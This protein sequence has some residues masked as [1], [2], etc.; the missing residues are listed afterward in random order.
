MK[1]LQIGQILVVYDP[2]AGAPPKAPAANALLINADHVS[3]TPSA[4][5]SPDM[6][7]PAVSTA[8]Q[9]S[10][11]RGSAPAIRMPLAEVVGMQ[12][13]RAA[14]TTS[15]APRSDTVCETWHAYKTS[16]ARK[17]HTTRSSCEADVYI[18]MHSAYMPQ[19][20]LQSF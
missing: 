7:G 9:F 2:G 20:G 14:S 3:G 19:V 6:K 18:Y 15:G 5:A 11:A 1:H 12:Q 8:R 13:E 17:N 4:G 16:A 10:P